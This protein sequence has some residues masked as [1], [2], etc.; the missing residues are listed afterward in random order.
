MNSSTYNASFLAGTEIRTKKLS[1][2]N[3]FFSDQDNHNVIKTLS[4]D[5]TKQNVVT[6]LVINQSKAIDSLGS[7]SLESWH[8]LSSNQVCDQKK[9]QQK[10]NEEQM[11]EN[12]IMKNHFRVAGQEN[13]DAYC[14]QKLLVPRIRFRKNHQN[15]VVAENVDK[16]RVNYNKVNKCH[17]HHRTRTRC[18]IVF[19][20]MVK[21][22]N[23]NSCFQTQ[24]LNVPTVIERRSQSKR[25]ENLYKHWP[26][27]RSFV[28]II[29]LQLVLIYV[30]LTSD[31]V[32]SIARASSAS[33]TNYWPLVNQHRYQQLFFANRMQQQPQHHSD[34]QNLQIFHRPQ[35]QVQPN[36][37]LSLKSSNRQHSTSAAATAA[38]AAAMAATANAAKARQSQSHNLL[39]GQN[40]NN[41]SSII[42]YSL[43]QDVDYPTMQE[44]PIINEQV[45]NLNGG[46]HHSNTDNEQHQAQLS[47]QVVNDEFDL[48]DSVKNSQ[49]DQQS[50]DSIV[51]PQTKHLDQH[52][53]QQHMQMLTSFLA[54]STQKTNNIKPAAS[55]RAILDSNRLILPQMQQIKARFNQ[56]CV[57]GTKCQFFAFCWMS[58]GSLGASCGLLMTCC[59]TPSRQEIQPGF[60][61]PVVNDPCK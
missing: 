49:F 53:V 29:A 4:L 25:C 32:S 35:L 56:G 26:L 18:K 44:D 3:E 21:L 46:Y 58:G 22:I 30:T 8:K 42:P 1:E 12:I 34:S 57:G 55:D 40:Y 9:K 59:V 43:M 6:K 2:S 5:T 51:Q 54:E 39:I 36:R 60:Y 27:S 50:S 47:Q 52:E 16:T 31:F 37:R 28:Q 41:F 14:N 48:S 19:D 11:L 7:M 33:T 24:Q 38:A 17:H 23:C 10:S 15:I 13:E 45:N 20:S 61:G